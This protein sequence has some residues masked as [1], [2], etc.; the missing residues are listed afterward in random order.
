MNQGMAFPRKTRDLHNHHMDSTVW[1]DFQFRGDD[2]IYEARAIAELGEDCA[3][4]LAQ[5]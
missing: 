1:D 2:V 5:R 3:A 4:W